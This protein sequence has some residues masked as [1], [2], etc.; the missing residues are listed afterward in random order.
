MI[1][2]GK[3][4]RSALYAQLAVQVFHVENDGIIRD[5]KVIA[6]FLWRDAA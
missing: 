6:D 2:L 4:F 1:V 5:F 3:Q